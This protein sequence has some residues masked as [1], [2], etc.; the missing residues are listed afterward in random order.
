VCAFSLKKVTHQI[1]NCRNFI[2]DSRL[3]SSFFKSSHS[4]KAREL[5]L[6]NITFHTLYSKIKHKAWDFPRPQAEKM[7]DV[8]CLWSL[9]ADYWLQNLLWEGLAFSPK[10]KMPVFLIKKNMYKLLNLEKLHILVSFC[11]LLLLFSAGSLLLVSL[12]LI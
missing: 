1:F 12:I 4:I 10:Q 11:R 3:S 2:N 9:S 5:I 7:K 6:L 8:F